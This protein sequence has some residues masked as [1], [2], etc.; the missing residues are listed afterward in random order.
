MRYRDESNDLSI[1]VPPRNVTSGGLNKEG[2]RVTRLGDTSSILS[3]P[4]IAIAASSSV[5][6]RFKRYDTAPSPPTPRAKKIGFPIPTAEA[7]RATV[8][9]HL[10]LM[11]QHIERNS[12]A[13]Q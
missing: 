9:I 11:I 1:L 7:P 2:C 8:H 4:Q 12:Q 6:N 5:C 13:I 10:R 3:I